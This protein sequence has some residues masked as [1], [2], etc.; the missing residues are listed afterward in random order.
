MNARENGWDAFLDLVFE[1]A[2]VLTWEGR[3]DIDQKL[4]TMTEVR[5]ILEKLEEL[6]NIPIVD[7]TI[8]MMK[9]EG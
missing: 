6:K 4:F 8:D 5:P 9:T 7:K 1:L 3:T 2:Q